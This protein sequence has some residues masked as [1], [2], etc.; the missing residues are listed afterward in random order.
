MDVGVDLVRTYTI[1]K[2]KR[3]AVS[4][5]WMIG[6]RYVLGGVICFVPRGLGAPAERIPR[7]C[8]LVHTLYR[9]SAAVPQNHFRT[10]EYDV[11]YWFYGAY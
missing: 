1:I 7:I 4:R 5:G 8:F 11:F 9:C 6:M 2:V 3:A 10:L